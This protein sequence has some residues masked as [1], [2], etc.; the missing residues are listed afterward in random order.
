MHTLVSHSNRKVNFSF[1]IIWEKVPF[2]IFFFFTSQHFFFAINVL[3]SYIT[4]YDSQPSFSLSSSHKH[5]L[6]LSD[7]FQEDGINLSSLDGDFTKEEMKR[8]I[9]DLSPHKSPS[10][11]GYPIF[12]FR[13]LWDAV[14]K[15]ISSL[16]KELFQKKVRLDRLNTHRSC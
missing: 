8:A 12:F 3:E 11:D 5:S 13:L 14:K 15:D 4:Q 10:L 7:D 2:W 1:L 16:F 9:W 6:T